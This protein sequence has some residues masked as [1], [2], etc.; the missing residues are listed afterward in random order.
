[1]GVLKS[2]FSGSIHSPRGHRGDIA[3]QQTRYSEEEEQEPISLRP[4]QTT[5]DGG[6]FE[7]EREPPDLGEFIAN[8]YVDDYGHGDQGIDSSTGYLLPNGY[9]VRM[10]P[11]ERYEDHRGAIPSTEAQRRWGWPEEVSQRM[12]EGNRHMALMEL[13][14]RSQAVRVHA[15][16]GQL[17]LHFAHE[18]THAQ[19]REIAQHVKDY[20]PDTVIVSREGGREI[21]LSN[22]YSGHVTGA[23]DES[24]VPEES[25]QD[26]RYSRQETPYARK[27]PPQGPRG[28]ANL[29]ALLSAARSD[30]YNTNLHGAIA[31]AL[32]EEHPGSPIP[33]LIRS[34]YGHGP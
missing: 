4:G 17:V 12:D 13:M 30:P 2:L 27:K 11:G 8:Q 15:G 24:A 14:R 26:S 20:R 34:E 1:M 9:G 5:P 33:D 3:I 16:Q 21:E 6:K 28:S 18:P 23:I 7:P 31:D 32:D 19:R 22:P 25:S 29:A 10:G